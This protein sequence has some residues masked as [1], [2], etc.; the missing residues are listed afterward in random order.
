MVTATTTNV[1]VFQGRSGR[2]YTINAAISDVVGA[3]VTFNANGAAAA[4]SNQY[5]RCPEP[6]VLTDAAFITG[7][8]VAAGMIMTQDGAVVAGSA[9]LLAGQLNT[10]ATRVALKVAFPA[11]SLIGATQF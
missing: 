5:W 7:P 9:L 8:T 1:F 11:G 10:L 2:I 6:V 4:G 3:A